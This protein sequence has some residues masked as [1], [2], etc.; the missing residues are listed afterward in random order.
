MNHSYLAFFLFSSFPNF[1][2]ITYTLNFYFSASVDV[3]D[4]KWVVF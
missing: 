4:T 1:D 2:A 3:Y